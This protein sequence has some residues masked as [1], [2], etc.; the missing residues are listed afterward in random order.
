LDKE[1]AVRTFILVIAIGIL[2]IIAYGD[3]RSRRIPNMLSFAVAALGFIRIILANDTAA[4]LHSIGAAVLILGVAFLLFWRGVIGGGDAKLIAAMA[5]L[6]ADHDLFSFLFLMSLCGGVLALAIVAE[7]KLRP[8]L[9]AWLARIHA[10]RA[11]EWMAKPAPSSVP[12]GVAIAVAGA[13]TLILEA[14]FQR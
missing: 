1:W 10:T 11:A 2:A 6:I 3:V 12:Y 9:L 4:A 8:Q 13:I 14:S 7:D 5:L